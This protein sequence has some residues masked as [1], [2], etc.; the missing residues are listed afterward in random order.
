MFGIILL[1][2]IPSIWGQQKEILEQEFAKRI[3]YHIDSFLKKKRLGKTKPISDEQFLR[4]VYLDIIGRI[5]TLKEAKRYLSSSEKD[6]KSK[7]IDK[8]QNSNGYVS[9]NYNYWGDSLR[10]RFSNNFPTSYFSFIKQSLYQNKPYDQFVNELLK[11]E[12]H[13][14][15]YRTGAI[16]YYMRDKNMPLDNLANTLTLFLGTDMVCAQCHDHPFDRW[17]QLDFYKLAAFSNGMNYGQV[18]KEYRNVVFKFEEAQRNNKNKAIL[19]RKMS[20][21]AYKSINGMGTGLIRLPSDYSYNDHKP[22]EY[23]E[24][25]VPFGPKVKLETKLRIPKNKVRITPKG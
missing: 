6:K 9:H 4:K 12:G 7:L 21:W 22:Y 5:P 10:L 15:D 18:P 16:G 25:G 17:S 13:L 24:A 1:S 23:V 11:A 8:L 2:F 19:G 20:E 3:N 14:E